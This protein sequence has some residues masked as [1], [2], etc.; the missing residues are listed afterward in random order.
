VLQAKD[1]RKIIQYWE[2]MV[3]LWD[4]VPVPQDVLSIPK[5]VQQK[6]E[7]DLSK[8]TEHEQHS[9]RRRKRVESACRYQVNELHTRA[10]RAEPEIGALME[11]LM[12]KHGLNASCERMEPNRTVRAQLSI[13]RQLV[14]TLIQRAIEEIGM[15]DGGSSAAAAAGAV[16]NAAGAGAGAGAAPTPV[17]SSA[18]KP[19]TPVADPSDQTGDGQSSRTRSSTLSSSEFAKVRVNVKLKESKG[20]RPASSS[21]D[22]ADHADAASG[23][24]G[25]NENEKLPASQRDGDADFIPDDGVIRNVLRAQE[26]ESPPLKYKLVIENELFYVLVLH[27]FLRDIAN[28]SDYEIYAINNWFDDTERFK[29]VNCRFLA[30]RHGIRFEVTF[31]TASSWEANVTHGEYMRR[32]F[33][34]VIKTDLLFTDDPQKVQQTRMQMR[35]EDMWRE[36]W[37]RIEVPDRALT[38]GTLRYAHVECPPASGLLEDALRTTGMQHQA[39]SSH[40]GGG[41]AIFRRA[42]RRAMAVA[43]MGRLGGE[44][45]RVAAVTGHTSLDSDD[46][47]GDSGDEPGDNRYDDAHVG[48]AWAEVVGR[49]F[50]ENKAVADQFEA[51]R[52]RYVA[53]MGPSSI[54]QPYGCRLAA[55]EQQLRQLQQQ[56]RGVVAPAEDG[57]SAARHP[58]DESSGRPQAE[59]IGKPVDAATVDPVDTRHRADVIWQRAQAAL[60]QAQA[61]LPATDQRDLGGRHA[62]QQ[63]ADGSSWLSSRNIPRNT[64]ANGANRADKTVSSP[65]GRAAAGERADRSAI[66]FLD[67]SA[68]ASVTNC[69]HCVLDSSS[70]VMCG[71]VDAAAIRGRWS[72]GRL[73]SI[74]SSDSDFNS[75]LAESAGVLYES[76]ETLRSNLNVV[77]IVCPCI[78]EAAAA[79]AMAAAMAPARPAGG[80]S[81]ARSHSSRKRQKS[82]KERHFNERFA[83]LSKEVCVLRPAHMATGWTATMHRGLF[84]PRFTYVK[85]ILVHQYLLAG[86]ARAWGCTDGVHGAQV[87]RRRRQPPEAATTSVPKNHQRHTIASRACQALRAKQSNH[88]RLRSQLS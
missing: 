86:A 58:V 45:Q 53:T 31:H 38:V 52:S 71:V 27:G 30:V 3:S 10:V 20:L 55:I 21:V 88:G 37:A 7:F 77:P 72:D 49:F 41:A 6:L 81:A 4:M 46:G 56:Q 2:E 78:G 51:F 47:G 5:V 54:W 57:S 9:I 59:Q 42:S 60:A 76:C 23:P 61:S 32:K 70:V 74:S 85:P 34:T 25:E 67:L 65:V 22:Y 28:D 87:R 62:W 75:D 83:S 16:V 35:R 8:L 19:S 79:M 17:D 50:A 66:G 68:P 40:R 11:F 63:E 14:D 64:A 36:R 1:S 33:D 12:K 82:R 39:S 43:R 24:S 15:Q 73:I 44:P 84:W 18:G 80:S 29:A 48:G 13:L 69:M 26:A